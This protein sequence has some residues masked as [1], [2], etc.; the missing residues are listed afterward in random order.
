[1]DAKLIILWGFNPAETVH[2]TNTTYYL[3][4]AKE[5]GAKNNRGGPALLRYGGSLADEW[6]LLPTTDNALMDAMIY[7]MIEENSTIGIL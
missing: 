5:A 7:V 2:G 6:I 1:M 4:R 3:R